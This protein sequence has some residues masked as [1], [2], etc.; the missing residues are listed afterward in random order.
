MDLKALRV[1]ISKREDTF[2]SL[3]FY[4]GDEKKGYGYYDKKSKLICLNRCPV[5]DKENWAMAVSTGVCAW[6]QFNPNDNNKITI[7]EA[8]SLP[9]KR[10]EICNI[11][12]F[13]SRANGIYCIK[14]TGLSTK[15]LNK[16]KGK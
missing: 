5:C 12:F 11:Q 15:Q 3:I 14:H 6:C 2:N 7:P 16:T 8:V 4:M 9:S 10:C 13:P 1:H